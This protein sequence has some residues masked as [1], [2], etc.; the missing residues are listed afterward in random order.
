MIWSAA[1][2]R[3]L[4][5]IHVGHFEVVYAFMSLEGEPSVLDEALL[6]DEELRRSR[7]FVRPRDRHHFV[8]AHAG[9]RLF[10]ARCL[11]VDPATVRYETGV[12]GKPRLLPGLPPLE[13]NL[14]HSEGLGLLAV[15]RDRS[16][17]VDIERIR[18]MPDARNIA[19]TYFSVAEREALRSLPLA[20]QEAAFFYCWT[21]KEA[22]IKAVGEGLSRALDS[23]EVDIGPGSVS[24]L[25]SLDDRPGQEA[26]LSLRDL[27]APFGYAAAGAVAAPAGLRRLWRELSIDVSKPRT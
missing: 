9:L 20:E 25:K 16:V 10:L 11:G 7:R 21:R 27:P 23:F 26:S 1:D 3:A 14:S 22:V 8:R 17:G 18:D 4:E 2:L 19:Q 15:A 13:F 6:D 12:H 24:A 5:G